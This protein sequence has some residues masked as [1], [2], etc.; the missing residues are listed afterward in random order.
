MRVGLRPAD[1]VELR[2]QTGQTQLDAV[3]AGDLID[4]AFKPAFAGRAIVAD[5]VEDE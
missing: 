2:F 4:R 3:D 5:D 1:F